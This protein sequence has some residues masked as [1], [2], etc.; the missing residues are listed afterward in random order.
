MKRLLIDLE[1]CACCDDDCSIQCGNLN[2]PHNAGVLSLREFAQFATVCRRCSDEPCVNSCPWQA[3]EKQ[4]DRVL[5]RYLMR[6]TSCKTCSHACPFGTIYPATIPLIASKCDFCLERL[7][8]GA[9]PVCVK[10]CEN[11]GL[12][13]GEFEPDEAQNIYQVSDYLLVKTDLKWSRDVRPPVK[14]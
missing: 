4:A 3:L 10:G 5:K 11:S 14:K 9:E 1:R 6:C 12:R 2:H 13:Y 7:P 8:D